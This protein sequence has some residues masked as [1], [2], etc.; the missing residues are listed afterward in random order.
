MVI[1][2]EMTGE[3]TV[4]MYDGP[5]AEG[6]MLISTTIYKPDGTMEVDGQLM[7]NQGRPVINSYI[8]DDPDTGVATWNVIEIEDPE[9]GDIITQLTNIETGEMKEERVRPDGWIVVHEEMDKDG[10]HITFLEAPT[11]NEQGNRRVI[12]MDY[13]GMTTTTTYFADRTIEPETIKTDANGNT[14]TEGYY[15]DEGNYVTKY[16]D[17]VLAGGVDVVRRTDDW[18]F[19]TLTYMNSGVETVD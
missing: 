12:V 7:D 16:F 5:V 6:G 14:V 19:Y 2:D 17:S 11:G 15:D 9:T 3:E 8:R 4:M 13:M 1:F 10:N 18:G